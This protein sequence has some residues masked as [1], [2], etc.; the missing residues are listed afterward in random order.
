MVVDL[1]FDGYQD[2]ICV[3][4]GGEVVLLDGFTKQPFFSPFSTGSKFTATPLVGDVTGDGNLE[5]IVS[6]EDGKVFFLTLKTMPEKRFE[7]NVILHGEFLGNAKNQNNF[8]YQR[9]RH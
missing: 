4:R 7:K 5:I 9:N 1:N 8:D 3:S 6:G 2:L